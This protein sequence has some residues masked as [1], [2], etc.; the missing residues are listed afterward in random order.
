VE[1]NVEMP[2][3]AAYGVEPTTWSGL[4]WMWAAERL[5]ANRNYW[6]VTASS[7]GQPHS[8]PVWGVWDPQ[9]NRFGFSCAEG[10]RKLRNIRENPLVSIT[11]ADT[12]EC[13]S[14]QGR[15]RIL[16]ALDAERAPFIDS[17]VAKYATDAPEGLA[18]FL[19]ENVLV[20]VDPM[21]AFGVIERE[22]DFSTRATRWRF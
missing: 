2:S 16:S 22:A 1:P 17:Y 5:V 13:I 6:V 14:V 9:S 10:A 4:P 18:E 20:I 19:Q 3:M 15:A 8:L 11:V 12:V 7:S 21:S